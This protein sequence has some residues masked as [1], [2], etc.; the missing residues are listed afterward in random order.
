MPDSEWYEVDGL[1]DACPNLEMALEA[2]T[3]ALAGNSSGP[4]TVVRY[5]SQEV[6]RLDKT[7]SISTTDLT[8]GP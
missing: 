7:I 8:S 4:L 3:S 1:T 5:T 6:A 2:A